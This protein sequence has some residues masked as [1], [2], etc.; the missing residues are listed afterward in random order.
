MD[1][2][3]DKTKQGLA[4]FIR[5]V[6]SN[7]DYLAM[8]PCVIVAQNADGTLELK[9]DDARLPPGFSKVPLRLGIPGCSVTV[10]AGSRVM[11]GWNNGVRSKPFA[12]LFESST[13][14]Q[15][16]LNATS[17][18]LNNGALA[19]ARV[20][21]TVTGTAGPYPLTGALIASGASGVS[22]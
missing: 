15:L 1:I 20:S 19:V 11:I 21:D 17:I 22:S 13:V 9:P 16:K 10:A 12:A 2:V 14:T 8:Y 3:L 18:V 5:S 6:L 7:V 4:A